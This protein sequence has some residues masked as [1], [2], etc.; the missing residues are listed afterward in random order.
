MLSKYKKYYIYSPN[1][2]GS[3][4]DRKILTTYSKTLADQARKK[5]Y[6]VHERI[7]GGKRAGKFLRVDK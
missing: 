4:T 2:T 7:K 3:L 5:G 1:K 6:I